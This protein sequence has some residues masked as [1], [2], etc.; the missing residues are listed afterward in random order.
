MSVITLRGLL[1]S[2]TGKYLCRHYNEK[3]NNNSYAVAT[4]F[5]LFIPGK[6]LSTL[7]TSF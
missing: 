5:D 6:S 4:Y 7:F 1:E 2:Q 3:F